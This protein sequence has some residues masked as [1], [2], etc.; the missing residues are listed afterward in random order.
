[1]SLDA[2]VR[3]FCVIQL[4][5]LKQEQYVRVARAMRI[6]LEELHL[7][8][9]PHVQS[10]QFQISD[11]LTVAAPPDM[12]KPLQIGT[13]DMAGQYQPF[14]QTTRIR[15]QAAND[16]DNPVDCDNPDHDGTLSSTVPSPADGIVFFNFTG[17]SGYIGELYGLRKRAFQNGQWRWNQSDGVIEFGTGSYI[18]S[19]QTVIL[20]YKSDMGEAVHY[21]VP[22]VWQNAISFRTLDLLTSGA[23]PRAAQQHF[24]RFKTEYYTIKRT[25]QNVSPAEFHAAIEEARY[26]SVKW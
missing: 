23:N 3:D 18:W 8:A 22:K 16:M 4:G 15:R 1:M 9:M 17:R 21:M 14:G 10:K 19:G 7:H 20:E 25:M 24:N 26:G 13:L 5:D 6:V 2:L 11:S 12:V